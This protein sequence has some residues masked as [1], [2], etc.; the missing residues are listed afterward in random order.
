MTITA[1]KWNPELSRFSEVLTLYQEV[2]TSDLYRTL[3]GRRTKRGPHTQRYRTKGY[4][5]NVGLRLYYR[6]FVGPKT[7]TGWFTLKTPNVF[8]GDCPRRFSI[9]TVKFCTRL[10]CALAKTSIVF[11]FCFLPGF[12]PVK[13]FRKM[14]TTLAQIFS[15]KKKKNW[16]SDLKMGR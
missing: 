3:L 13:I 5:T 2:V 15:A 16:R 10:L 8:L 6:K 9:H 11:C 7:I 4:G 1:R 12:S 14:W